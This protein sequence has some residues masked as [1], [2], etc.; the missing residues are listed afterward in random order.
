MRGMNVNVTARRKTACDAVQRRIRVFCGAVTNDCRAVLA[1]VVRDHR[2][3][4]DEL[5]L[6]TGQYGVCRPL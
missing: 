2:G 4:K 6:D 1:M 5:E 3:D